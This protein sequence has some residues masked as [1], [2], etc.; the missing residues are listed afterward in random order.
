MIICQSGLTLNHIRSPSSSKRCLGTN[1][2]DI[3]V[4]GFL[5]FEQNYWIQ[6]QSKDVVGMYQIT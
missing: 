6:L 2:K 4:V 1:I 3:Y 5:L